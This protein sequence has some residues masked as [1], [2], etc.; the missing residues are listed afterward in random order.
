[1]HQW[2][3]GLLEKEWWRQRL[4]SC[5]F[6]K[7]Q[8]CRKFCAVLYSFH[9]DV[10]NFVILPSREI[11]CMQ[12]SALKWKLYSSVWVLLGH[13]PVQNADLKT[14]EL[15]ICG[16]GDNLESSVCW[17]Y[18][19]IFLTVKDVMAVGL[20]EV[21]VCVS[22]WVCM[23]VL[24]YAC[25]CV[26]VGACFCTGACVWVDGRT[27][28]ERHALFWNLHKSQATFFS[29][30]FCYFIFFN[31]PKQSWNQTQNL[32]CIHHAMDARMRLPKYNFA[33]Y[34]FSLIFLK[35]C[36]SLCVSR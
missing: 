17:E 15:I 24:A 28:G 3:H 23:C 2:W 26:G 1:M 4:L 13:R 22:A 36:V 14:V 8:F 35:W 34:L 16:F 6:D 7:R 30:C 10:L 18:I 32:T 12:L 5:T 33:K 21:C 31:L 29:S 25:V 19:S 11:R 20:I 9:Y 27:C